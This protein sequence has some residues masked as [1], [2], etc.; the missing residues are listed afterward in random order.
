MHELLTSENLGMR[1]SWVKSENELGSLTLIPVDTVVVTEL[2][3]YLAEPPGCVER[4]SD[5]GLQGTVADTGQTSRQGCSQR[6][7]ITLHKWPGQG[8]SPLISCA[9]NSYGLI[10]KGRGKKRRRR[11]ELMMHIQ[12]KR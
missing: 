6:A 4:A 5:P 3:Q 10:L 8:F 12:S 2:S 7:V 11:K 1:P 9:V